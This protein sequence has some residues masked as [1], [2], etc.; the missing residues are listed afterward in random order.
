MPD[1]PNWKEM[2]EPSGPAAEKD[3]AKVYDERYGTYKDAVNEVVDVNDRLPT[4]QMPKAP[5]PS[6]FITR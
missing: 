2:G 3:A 4:A 1:Q 5:D 6:P